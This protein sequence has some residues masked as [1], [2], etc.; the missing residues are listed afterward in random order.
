MS[1][2]PDADETQSD[3]RRRQELSVTGEK[4]GES[5]TVQIFVMVLRALLADVT[6]LR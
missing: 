2:P 1:I 3:R 6:P 5:L 4:F